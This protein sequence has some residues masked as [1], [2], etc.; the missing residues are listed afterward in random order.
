[1]HYYLLNIYLLWYSNND[2]NDNVSLK[3]W[4]CFRWIWIKNNKNQIVETCPSNRFNVYIYSV[5]V[6]IINS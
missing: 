5:C 1:M 2:K 6:G 3:N 4:E